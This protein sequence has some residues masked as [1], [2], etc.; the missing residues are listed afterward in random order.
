MWAVDRLC[1]VP[2]VHGLMSPFPG[3]CIEGISDGVGGVFRVGLG[4]NET[5]STGD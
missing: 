4:G 1:S 3:I 5:I 2:R